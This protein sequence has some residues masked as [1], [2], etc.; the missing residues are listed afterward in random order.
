MSFPGRGVASLAIIVA[1]LVLWLAGCGGERESSSALQGADGS[2][3]AE[4][5]ECHAGDSVV[6]TVV[7]DAP[8]ELVYGEHTR[9]RYPASLEIPGRANDRSVA[10]R[11]QFVLPIPNPNSGLPI[12]AFSRGMTIVNDEDTDFDGIDDRVQTFMSSLTG[13]TDGT[14]VAI[15]FDCVDTIEWPSRGA[16]RVRGRRRCWGRVHRGRRPFDVFRGGRCACG[17]SG[18]SFSP[19]LRPGRAA[20]TRPSR[21]EPGRW[22]LDWAENENSGRVLGGLTALGVSLHP[23]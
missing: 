3:V 5:I 15:R 14:F 22:L 17:G 13:F 20:E 8:G 7:V 10:D 1:C 16:V 23:P 6:V 4:K 2:D 9:L 18:R 12:D 21:F 11:V 19:P